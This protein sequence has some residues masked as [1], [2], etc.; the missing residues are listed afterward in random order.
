MSEEKAKAAVN[1]DKS[2][3]AVS[4]DK[5]VSAVSG[6]KPE[7]AVSEDKPKSAAS[8]DRPKFGGFI[9]EI[10]DQDRASG[11]YGGRVHTRFPPEP[12]GYLHIGHAKAICIDFGL[13]EANG[14][15]CNLRFDDTN[16]SKEE[17][18]YVESIKEDIRWLGFDWGDRLFFASDYFDR[19]Y[20]YAV[21][22]I[23]RGKAYVCD[24]TPEE[25][26]E[27]RGTLTEPG[28]NSP[29]RD[30]S[31][32]ENMDLFRRMKEGEFSDGA[33]ALREDR[34]GIAEHHHERSGAYGSS[35]CLTTEPVIPGAYTR[36]TTTLILCRMLSRASPILCALRV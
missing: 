26:R 15:L 24:L 25:I 4:G 32:E 1:E 21:E 19:L 7:S 3:S 18:E 34:Y 2:K 5:P 22:L 11:K 35:E 29:Y 14:G 12:N 33:R 6:D 27:Y 30:R 8:G 28:R 23:K 10:I 13:A 9:Q 36:L 20:E 17:V 31:V 16:P